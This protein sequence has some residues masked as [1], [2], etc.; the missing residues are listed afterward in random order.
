MTPPFQFGYPPLCYA[1]LGGGQG[2]YH[3]GNELVITDL[4]IFEAQSLG[5][6]TW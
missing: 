3:A 4:L 5:C 2:T 6:D 1:N